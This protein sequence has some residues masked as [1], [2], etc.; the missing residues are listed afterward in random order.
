MATDFAAIFRRIER[1]RNLTIVDGRP[2]T[3]RKLSNHGRAVSR[4]CPLGTPQQ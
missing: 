2:L 1:R 3:E 4:L